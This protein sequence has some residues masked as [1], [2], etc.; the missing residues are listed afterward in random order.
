M[1]PYCQ[2]AFFNYGENL[3][4]QCKRYSY[5]VGNSAVQE[6]LAGKSFYKTDVAAVVSKKT[7]TLSAKGI[8]P[9]GVFL[10]H[11]EMLPELEGMIEK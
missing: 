4:L 6:V 10:L 9:S 11:H 2:R 5:P 3:V 1:R 7:F 8:R